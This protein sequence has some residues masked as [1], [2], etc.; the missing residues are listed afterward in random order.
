MRSYWD[1]I[2]RKVRTL[3]EAIFLC[4]YKAKNETLSLMWS[5]ELKEY[6]NLAQEIFTDV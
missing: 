2:H 1:S 4:I 6:R 3:P 5:E